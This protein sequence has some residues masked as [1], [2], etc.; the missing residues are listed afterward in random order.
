MVMGS[1]AARRLAAGALV[2][3]GLV[4]FRGHERWSPAAPGPSP[5]RRGMSRR[6]M[7]AQHHH[8]KGKASTPA[9]PTDFKPD[10]GVV[11]AP[12]PRNLRVLYC[13]T[14]Y[15]R[16]QHVHL[17]QMLGSVVSMCEGGLQV[18]LVLYTADSNPYTSSQEAEMREILGGCSGFFGGS[19]TFKLLA[20]PASLKFDMTMQH[21]HEMRNRIDDFDVFVYAE[22]DIHVEVRHVM[23]YYHEALKLQKADHG[24]KYVLGWQRFEKNGIGM[25]A[26]QVMWENGVDSYHAVEIGGELYVTMVNPHAGA[27]IATR[28]ELKQHHRQCHILSVPKTAGSF[29]RVRAGGWNLYLN[30]GRRKVM[31][32]KNIANFLIHHLPD[33]N[34][35]QRSECAIA[36]PAL[37][38]H[39]RQWRDAYAAGDRTMVCGDWWTDTFCRDEMQVVRS[40]ERKKKYGVKGSCTVWRNRTSLRETINLPNEKMK[41]LGDIVKAKEA[42][43]KVEAKK[44]ERQFGVPT[45]TG[46]Q[47]DAALVRRADNQDTAVGGYS[48]KPGDAWRPDR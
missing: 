47:I 26:D 2:L 29:T 44:L 9:A 1:V 33:K 22:D 31:P 7:R 11:E 25:G 20:L 36:V 10:P 43:A 5:A 21:R 6:L 16:K 14:A 41:R 8:Q 18:E 32:V 38:D 42:A 45:S 3:L 24:D 37:L 4:L 28:D 40:S 48:N 39:M 23:T 15:D 12:R 19:V 46:G 30:C 17:L 13:I 35:W 34:W 27:W